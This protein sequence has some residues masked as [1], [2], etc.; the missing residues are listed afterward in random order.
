M[1]Y[2]GGIEGGENAGTLSL[3]LSY[4]TGTTGGLTVP[5]GAGT[6]FPQGNGSLRQDMRKT[7]APRRVPRTDQE[8]P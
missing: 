5:G 4:L 7:W 8:E 6:T 1:Y 2:L 3:S